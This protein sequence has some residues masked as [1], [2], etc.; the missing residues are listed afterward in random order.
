M[1][2]GNHEVVVGHVR[3]HDVVLDVRLVLHGNAYL[4][5][6]V[7]DVHGEV[8]CEAVPLDDLPVVF[9][10]VA[11]IFLVGRSVAVGGVALHD[12]AVNLKHQ[13]FHE[14]GLQ[15]VGVAALAG[16]HLHGHAPF[17]RNAQRLVDFHQC[18]G[19]DFPGQ[20]NGALCK[21]CRC[22]QHQSSNHCC[23]FHHSLFSLYKGKVTLFAEEL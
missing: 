14:L 1:V 9:R 22:H 7:H 4:A 17:C 16:A 19:T 12:G 23:L 21:G 2:E 15:E 8:L 10:R 13:V 3:S 5:I 20:V 18:R 6:F 11:L